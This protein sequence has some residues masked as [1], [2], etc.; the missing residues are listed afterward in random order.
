TPPPLRLFVCTSSRRPCPF[1]SHCHA[2]HR[3]LPSFPTRRS[4]DLDAQQ[5]GLAAPRWPEQTNDLARRHIQRDT[6]QGH[7]VAVAALD[8][9]R[10]EEHTSEL[11]S[12][13]NLVCRLLLEKKKKTKR[14]TPVQKRTTP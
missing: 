6:A 2:P 13:E 14:P 3:D 8:G 9:L 7:H 11:Q 12:R 1:S 10:S 5:R 4:S